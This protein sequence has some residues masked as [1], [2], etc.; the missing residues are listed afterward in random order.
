MDLVC[1]PPWG[2][3]FTCPQ[4]WWWTG[5]WANVSRDD[6]QSIPVATGDFWGL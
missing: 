1:R 5:Y 4:R 3:R 2:M 6:A